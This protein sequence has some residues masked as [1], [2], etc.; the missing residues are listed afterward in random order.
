ML[1]SAQFLN[2]RRRRVSWG[3]GVVEKGRLQHVGEGDEEGEDAVG[4]CSGARAAVWM[5]R[6]DEGVGSMQASSSCGWQLL[7]RILGGM[8]VCGSGCVLLVGGGWSLRWDCNWNFLGS[9]RDTF[10]WPMR[11][12]VEIVTRVRVG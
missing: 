8:V 7:L 4:L 1:D 6:E 5:E 12:G 11:S 10:G 3:A 9:G 2:C